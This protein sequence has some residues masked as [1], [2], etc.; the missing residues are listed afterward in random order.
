MPKNEGGGSETQGKWNSLNTVL[1][2][3]CRLPIDVALKQLFNAVSSYLLIDLQFK[4]YEYSNMLELGT[5]YVCIF[6]SK[7]LHGLVFFE[8]S[9]I[10]V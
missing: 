1:Y 7:A 8:M 10:H 9:M 2:Y 4:L 5:R 6:K 3:C